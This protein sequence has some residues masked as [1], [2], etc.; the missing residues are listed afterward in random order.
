MTRKKSTASRRRK[1]TRAKAGHRK[2]ATATRRRKSEPM[3][4]ETHEF[5]TLIEVFPPGVMD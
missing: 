5:E 2:H 4:R 3:K 1:T